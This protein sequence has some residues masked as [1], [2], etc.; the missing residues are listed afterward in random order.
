[1]ALVGEVWLLSGNPIPLKKGI[2]LKEFSTILE[3]TRVTKRKK[4]GAFL[5][6]LVSVYFASGFTDFDTSNTIIVM[7]TSVFI[8]SLGIYSIYKPSKNNT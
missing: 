4:G 6:I 3:N 7:V 2:S 1:M 8:I 5:L